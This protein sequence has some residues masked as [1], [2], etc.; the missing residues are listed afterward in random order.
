MIKLYNFIYQR[1]I[2]KTILTSIPRIP[3]LIFHIPIIPN[4][5]PRIPII[6]LIPFTISHLNFFI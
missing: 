1:L 3:T 5:I 6:S 4:L 2:W